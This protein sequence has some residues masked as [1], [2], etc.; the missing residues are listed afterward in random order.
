MEKNSKK[1]IN[2]CLL[3]I[4]HWLQPIYFMSLWFFPSVCLP[5]TCVYMCVY[6]SIS[7]KNH[8]QRTLWP[9]CWHVWKIDQDLVAFDDSKN[10]FFFSRWFQI[11]RSRADLAHLD[12]ARRGEPSQCQ[13]LLLH[14]PIGQQPHPSPGEWE[15]CPWERHGR[16]KGE[17]QAGPF[18]NSHSV[19][20]EI[21]VVLKKWEGTS[22]SH[23]FF[24]HRSQA[25][26]VCQGARLPSLSYALLIL[27]SDKAPISQ[28]TCGVLLCVFPL[29]YLL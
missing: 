24:L 20:V 1:R 19:W 12:W 22:L 8:F 6:L 3:K 13:Q 27:P 16:S 25:Y 29:V 4:L 28:D 5:A 18:W 9:H 11:L 15:S 14:D 23:H 10:K 21:R 7:F 26:E 17:V 2:I